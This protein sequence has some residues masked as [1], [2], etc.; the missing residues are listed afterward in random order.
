MDADNGANEIFV[1]SIVLVELI[2]LAEHKRIE[3]KLVTD[4]FDLL[5]ADSANYIVAPLDIE[6][7][8]VLPDI[9]RNKIPDMPDR[10]IV[11]TARRLS[12]PLITRDQRITA[13]GL[14][15]LVW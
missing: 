8:R 4:A 1:P 14:V 6:T 5:T 11:S 2:Y 12:I 7:A 9:D 3:R 15:N 13:S 10:V